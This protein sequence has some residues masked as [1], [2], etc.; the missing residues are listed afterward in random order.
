VMIFVPVTAPILFPALAAYN[1][2][3]T[4]DHLAHLYTEGNLTWTEGIKGVA[5]IGLNVLPYLGSVKRVADL[6][7][8][9]FYTLEGVLI[10]GQAL[11]MTADALKALHEL[12]DGDVSE[13]AKLD[14][15]IKEI[16]RTNPSDPT[17]PAKRKQLD[18]LIKKAQDR[19]KQVFDG[20]AKNLGFLLVQTAGLK[21]LSKVAP[22]GAVGGL[23]KEGLWQEKAGVEP[24]YDAEKGVI[25]GDSKK[26]TPERME[27][28]KTEFQADM[29]SKQSEM[30]NLLGTDNFTVNR[31]A[32]KLEVKKTA[33]GYEVNMPEGTKWSDAL[34][35]AWETRSKEAGAPPERPKSLPEQ[36]AEKAAAEKVAAEKA[37]AAEQAAAAEKAA[38]EKLA[39]EKAAEKAAAEKAA[40]AEA[41]RIKDLGFDPAT[42]KYRP[43][44]SATAA[45]VEAKEGVK[46]E[47]FQPKPGEK[48]DWIDPVK[49]TV[50]DGCSP[51]KSSF[52]DGQI[53]NGAY[54][55]SLLD[56]VN[57]PTVN[58]VVVDTTGLGLTPAQMAVLD[59]LLNP[60]GAKILRIP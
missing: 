56:H 48:G 17:L 59:G 27:T 12:R 26:M 51:P 47:R 23:K 31:N 53:K 60:H 24:K 28:L 1:S 30:A 45:R 57:H 35:K 22:E 34:S 58:K 11:L 9:A 46:L 25:V 54:N 39:A 4:I 32:K 15:E 21:A 55:K 42:K 49:G 29:A 19:S 33:D 6:G 3:K 7:K 50:Y 52:F 40:V 43:N 16:E 14:A 8:V 10:G 38:A 18:A 20:L 36:A 2:I 13:I 41:E 37:A 5:E 44:E